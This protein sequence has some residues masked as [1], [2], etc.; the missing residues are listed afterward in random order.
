MSDRQHHAQPTAMQVEACAAEWLARKKEF[1]DW[2]DDDQLELDAWLQEAPAHLLAYA[3]L[4]EAWKSADRLCALRTPAKESAAPQTRL[5]YL[6]IAAVLMILGVA[7]V[8]VENVRPQAPQE[9][10]FSTPIGGRQV[11]TLADG[12]R[13]ELNTNTV[14]RVALGRDHR[15]IWLDKGEAYFQVTH[16]AARPF[17][18]YANGRRITDLGTKFLVRND[19]S[20]LEVALLEGRVR[21]DAATD[22]PQA[23]TVLTAG[24][25]AIAAGNT[26]SV[27]KEPIH[28]VLAK[29]GWRRGVITFD[30][31]TLADAAAE[32]NRYNTTKI[33]IADPAVGSITI[34]G[35]FPTNDVAAF[36][37][38]ARDT[39]K[40]H[41]KQTNG[42]IVISR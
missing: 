19:S 39:F 18:I 14:L 20:R 9:K 21:F 35:T 17:V 33:V 31:A 41:A 16:D 22:E 37:E 1:G 15:T 25:D 38:A 32:F 5:P 42:E 12:S 26:T 13:M 29:L 3:R 23:M 24:D 27:A 8:V 4:D 2:S 7:A 10:T 36:A 30:H 34:D 28:E 40:L 6:R 11:L